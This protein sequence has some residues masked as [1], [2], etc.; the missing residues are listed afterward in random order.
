MNGIYSYQYR[1]F[2]KKIISLSSQDIIHCPGQPRHDESPG[3]S[4]HPLGDFDPPQHSWCVVNI[5]E[6]SI[7]NRHSKELEQDDTFPNKFAHL[8]KRCPPLLNLPDQQFISRHLPD[9]LGLPGVEEPG[10]KP[11]IYVC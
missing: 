9:N 1:F 10:Q 7:R 4:Y 11:S 3:A 8:T 5:R 6:R 2:L